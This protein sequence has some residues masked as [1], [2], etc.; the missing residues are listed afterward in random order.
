MKATLVGIQAEANVLFPRLRFDIEL[1]NDSA[2]AVAV[3]NMKGRLLFEDREEIGS[4]V[5]LDNFVMNLG[6]KARGARAYL[7]LDTN[8]WLLEKIEENRKGGNMHLKINISY[9]YAKGKNMPAIDAIYSETI[10]VK[11]PDGG[12]RQIIYQSKWLSILQELKY[13]K[14]KVFEIKMPELP[15]GTQMDKGVQYLVNAQNMMNAGNYKEVIS[16]CRQAME[17]FRKIVKENSTRISNKIDEGSSPPTGEKNKSEKLLELRES[18]HKW[19]HIG[20]HVAYQVERKDAELALI[21]TLSI[22]KY[23]AEVLLETK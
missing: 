8:P 10:I 13:S 22:G 20:P 15:A 4:L 12:E 11:A 1:E 19:L 9:L 16:N 2:E 18:I 7:H 21:S 14:Y 5:L 17:D 6:S 3:F 23:L